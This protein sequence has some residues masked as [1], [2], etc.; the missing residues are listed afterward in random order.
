MNRV[1]D[2]M[3]AGKPRCG[4]CKQTLDVSG[5]PQEVGDEAFDEAIRASPVPVMVDFWAPW[6]GPCRAAA[7]I[8]ESLGRSHA[9]KVVVLKLNT[10][11]NQRTASRYSIASI[12]S[13]YV[14]KDG[15]VIGQQKGLPPRIAFERWLDQTIAA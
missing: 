12:P 2:P 7:P 6:C 5:A 1:P 15:K 13:F 11:E 8:V 10:D 14:F 4:R 9:G 3:P